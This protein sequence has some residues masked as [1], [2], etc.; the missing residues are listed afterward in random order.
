MECLMYSMQIYLNLQMEN[1]K[2]P[3]LNL[4]QHIGNSNFHT[5]KTVERTD[6]FHIN[7]V[8][9]PSDHFRYFQ[10]FLHLPTVHPLPMPPPQHPRQCLFLWPWKT[11]AL[12]KPWEENPPTKQNVSGHQIERKSKKKWK[13]G[14]K[15]YFENSL[16]NDA[17][18]RIKNSGIPCIFRFSSNF[19]G[20]FSHLD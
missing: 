9:A 15:K 10:F 20:E 6:N 5:W 8:V 1:R 17:L 14:T 19:S 18:P 7:I 4:P 12:E 13:N 2:S 11:A 16:K 3:I